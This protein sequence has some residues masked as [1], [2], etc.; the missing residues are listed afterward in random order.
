MNTA[1]QAM[2]VLE[3]VVVALLC[4]MI[5]RYDRPNDAR[6]SVASR[7]LLPT[8]DACSSWQRKRRLLLLSF[9]ALRRRVS[10]RRRRRRQGVQ[11]RGPR[12][13]VHGNRI[14]RAESASLGQSKV[15]HRDSASARPRLDN[16]LNAGAFACVG[17]EISS[18]IWPI[19]YDGLGLRLLP[20]PTRPELG[21][22]EY[23]GR[24][25]WAVA[26]FHGPCSHPV[27]FEPG[28]TF[29]NL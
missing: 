23:M 6:G 24:V 15:R 5:C 14:K 3:F 4:D 12:G 1:W 22:A 29:S 7:A 11:P 16:G 8:S 21:R 25:A 20:I 27:C 26:R 18:K 17:W 28:W 13:I 2:A 9:D 19:Y 10:R